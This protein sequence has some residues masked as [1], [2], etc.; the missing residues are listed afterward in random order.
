[1]R[2]KHNPA[3]FRAGLDVG[4]TTIKLFI[5]DAQGQ[6][7]YKDYQRHHTQIQ[8][9]LLKM[10]ELVRDTSGNVDLRLAVSGSAG[11]G[12]SER[13]G[14][15]FIQEVVAA[16]EVI[17]QHYP[18]V[19]SLIDIGGE[20]SKLIFLTPGKAPD[21]RMNGNCAGGTGAFIDQ[22]AGLLN[23]SLKELNR[24]A[25]DHKHLY[26]IASRCGVFAK[27]DI[28][29]L[30]SRHIPKTDIAA[31]V[32]HA[33]AIQTMNALS[34]GY[35]ISPKVMFIGGP[36]T[37]LPYMTEIFKHDL[38]LN[39]QDVITTEHPAYLPAWGAAID[40]DSRTINIDQLIEKV[41]TF[42]GV[43]NQN[44]KSIKPLFDSEQD[45]QQWHK[46]RVQYRVPCTAI[47][48]Y[49]SQ[50]AFLGI[51]SGST[52]SK[53][54]LIGD[55]QELLFADYR[56][57][58]GNPIEA[59][60]QALKKLKT[61]IDTS[62]KTLNIKHTTITGYGEDLI[63]AALNAETGVVE[64]IAHFMAARHF[65]PKVSFVLDIGGQD[66]K[67]IFVENGSIQR[68][69]LNESCSS[70]CGSFIETFSRSLNYPVSD[71]AEMACRAES[72]ADLG[73]RCTV[74]MNSK[75]KQSLREQASIEDIAAGLS[76]S[77]IKNALYKV[78]KL[79]RP[80]ELGKHIVVQGGTFRNLSVHRA[81]E[82]LSGR[83]VICSDRP[84][85]MGAY[86]AA[87]TAQ[88]LYDNRQTG[89]ANSPV[90]TQLE[91]LLDYSSKSQTCKACVNH[92]R[93][94]RFTFA[95][96]RHFYSG[97][98]C[99]A[100]FSNKGSSKAKGQNLFQDKLKLLF[101]RPS[102]RKEGHLTL[103]I[104]RV[105]NL[106][107]NY[108]FWHS[109]LTESGFN[110]QLSPESTMPVYE[111]GSG[112]VMSDSICFPAKLVHGHIM[113]LA[114][115]E[116]DRI[117]YPF[118]VYE[119][120]EFK[121]A[122]NTYNCP[123]VS[124]YADVIRS[125]IN[126]ERR[127]NIPLDS[128]VVH[129]GD[130]ALLRKACWQYL[131]GL[132]VKKK[133]F[134]KAFDKALDSQQKY[135]NE[136]RRRA[137]AIINYAQSRNELLVVLAGRPY[138]A[139]PLIN[140]KTPEIL[141]HLGVH[142]ITED[143][144]PL[145]DDS[146]LGELQIR[147]QW[148][149]PNRIFKAA[150]WVA[151]QNDK[152]QMAQFNSFG[153][154]PD[155]IALD[156]ASEILAAAGKN[157]SLIRIDE[158][159]ATGSVR[160]RLR[161]MVESLALRSTEKRP[162]KQRLTTAVFEAKDKT[163]VILAPQFSYIYNYFLP[164]I[165]E[166]AGYKLVNL[167][168]PD[169][170]SI[171]YGLKYTNNEIC[172]PA[173]IIVGDVM[174]ALQSGKYRREDIAIGITQTGGQCRASS[175]LALIKKGMTAAGFEDIPVVSVSTSGGTLNPQPG[176]E[177]N[178]MKILKIVFVAALYADSLQKLYYAS[179]VRE[180]KKGSSKQLLDKYLEAVQFFVREQNVSAIYEL[181]K[182]AVDE[183][184]QLSINDKI[185]PK[186]GIV[187]EIYV[188]YNTFGNHHAV[189]WLVEQGVEV[190]VPPLLEFFIQGFVNMDSDIKH[191][192]DHRKRSNYLVYFF[193]HL[194]NR[195]IRRTQRIMAAYRF[196]QPF[197]NLRH[198]AK[199]AERILSLANQF[200]E[201]WLIPADIA[202]F[203]DEGVHHVISL[204][205]FGC[206]ANQVIAK[207]VEKRIKDLYPQMNLLFLDFDSSISE[208]NVLNRL[209]F[210][211][212]NV[213]EAARQQN[214]L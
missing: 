84:E 177:I 15:S 60:Y 93:I 191:H 80:D 123:I 169:Q 30:L 102:T 67:A 8:A 69:E 39:N 86:G 127:F 5:I 135:K 125:A 22:M 146:K 113:A 74:F 27:T 176:F 165:F 180:V 53:V 209:H 144:I 12:L 25:E 70:G 94:T 21:I 101:D 7:V 145:D 133:T 117:F 45:F 72:P 28:Q 77:V 83:E 128:P 143:A 54:C 64:T 73:T 90:L 210:M 178:W 188:K 136:L 124:S 208:V 167:P 140:H 211:L 36:F 31:S 193:E 43:V 34:R 75:V 52:T 85:M 171:D 98:K 10:F 44:T 91:S 200:G 199:R 183:F 104:P 62:G 164:T 103:G 160:L 19:R 33:V 190:V 207:G 149:Y 14:W 172:Y 213:Q 181:L 154:G 88:T 79:K 153:C 58:D 55:H 49:P 20:D 48:D 189:D 76:I 174:K 29:N 108:P 11:I 214:K 201:G 119:S 56:N 170:H 175:Y 155:V 112:T 81:L 162:Q 66:M 46:R 96:G 206:I 168:P 71:F 179:I 141:E 3:I 4:S 82:Q 2:S 182:Q 132:K 35:D 139:D 63:K 32:F 109:L 203:A 120:S 99:E 18:Q 50:Q 114:K 106:F 161:S 105:L 152:I 9:S 185:Y 97:N 116:V 68:I 157:N 156:E 130:T 163:R 198:I 192:L 47:K 137:E 122:D 13:F 129:F 173:T 65:N 138:H 40:A 150:K 26:P 51:D 87:L 115:Q 100:V 126:T 92:C 158:I 118:A 38:K 121:D 151:A 61:E 24:L 142:I 107:E 212:K 195:H 131:K 134:L 37:F 147:S 194:A 23:V 166:L 59:V 186:I 42:K 202:A 16:S 205:P 196:N 159:T 57:N 197:H 187:G 184:N 89:Q 110:V 78:L 17:K 204:Q 1:M 111:L 95:N 6:I 41:S 148:S